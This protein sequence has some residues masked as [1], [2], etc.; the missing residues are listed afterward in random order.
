[1]DR[2]LDSYDIASGNFF[3]DYWATGSTAPIDP[4]R[5][6][7]WTFPRLRFLY[8]DEISDVE[9]GYSGHNAGQVGHI[10]YIWFV[11][12]TTALD[13]VA[14]KRFSPYVTKGGALELEPDEDDEYEEMDEPVYALMG[15]G[16]RWTPV[17][18][19]RKKRDRLLALS[20]REWGQWLNSKSPRG[21]TV[22]QNIAG[23]YIANLGAPATPIELLGFTLL[24]AGTGSEAGPSLNPKNYG[25]RG[26][27]K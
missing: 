10:G 15:L 14:G 22:W 21:G 8:S 11:V 1:M 20:P 16:V 9:L 13:H 27:H 26:K 4:E 3:G 18:G 2:E 17:K 7:Q 25:M 24:L 12:E 23:S 19:A 5:D 6:L